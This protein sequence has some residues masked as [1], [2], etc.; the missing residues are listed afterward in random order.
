M[1]K[2]DILH[3]VVKQ[4]LVKSGWEITDD[5]DR[6]LYLAVTD[7]IYE[8]I[9]SEPIGEVV[10]NELPLHLLVVNV[11]N[12]EIQKWIPSQAIATS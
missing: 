9:F 10:I 1:P 2:R 5:P 12:M 7:E 4:A 8:D 11:E 6:S 3:D